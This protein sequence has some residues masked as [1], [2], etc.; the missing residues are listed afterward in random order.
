MLPYVAATWAVTQLLAFVVS[1]V[2]A[3]RHEQGK[4]LPPLAQPSSRERIMRALFA[5]GF[6]SFA[7]IYILSVVF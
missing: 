3:V 6:A 1:V 7:A 2:Y 4:P 5:N